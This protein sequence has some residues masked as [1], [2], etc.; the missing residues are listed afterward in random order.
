MTS[1]CK[2]PKSC[3]MQKGVNLFCTVL[4]VGSSLKTTNHRTIDTFN[5]RKH[6][7]IIRMMSWHPGKGMIS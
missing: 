1:V 4:G 5:L 2:Y 3:H 6:L 7:L